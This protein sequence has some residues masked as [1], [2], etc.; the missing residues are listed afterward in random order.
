M[1]IGRGITNIMKELDELDSKSDQHQLTGQ[2]L[3]RKKD[4][5]GMLDQIWKVEEIKP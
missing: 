3:R 1:L 4:L 2:E 5:V